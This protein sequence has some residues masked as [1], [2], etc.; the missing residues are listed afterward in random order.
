MQQLFDYSDAFYFVVVREF[1]GDTSGQYPYFSWLFETTNNASMI[2]FVEFGQ[3][4]SCPTFVRFYSCQKCLIVKVQWSTSSWLIFQAIVSRFETDKL[5]S[6]STFA[7]Y[8][9][10]KK[11]VDIRNYCATFNLFLKW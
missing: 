2:R 3:Y 5:F 9:F 10:V 4:S 8:S 7:D 6:I 11:F 1:V